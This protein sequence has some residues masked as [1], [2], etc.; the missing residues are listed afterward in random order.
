MYWPFIETY[1]CKNTSWKDDNGNSN[2]DSDNDN[3]ND[4]DDDDNSDN[5]T[6]QYAGGKQPH[7]DWEPKRCKLELGF[8]NKHLHQNYVRWR[9]ECLTHAHALGIRDKLGVGDAL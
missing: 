3:D 8:A 9:I 2:D 5:G 4:D 6:K 7:S 1:K